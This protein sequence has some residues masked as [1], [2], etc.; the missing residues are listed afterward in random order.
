MFVVFFCYLKGVHLYKILLFFYIFLNFC[1]PL[2]ILLPHHRALR[3]SVLSKR[4][5]VFI[6]SSAS[7]CQVLPWFLSVQ[8]KCSKYLDRTGA[9]DHQGSDPQVPSNGQTVSPCMIPPLS[10]NPDD[11]L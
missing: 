9:E 2:V 3:S 6:L 11:D 8:S 7:L 10:I 4:T 1:V 5:L